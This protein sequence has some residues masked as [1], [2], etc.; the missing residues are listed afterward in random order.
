MRREKR[1]MSCRREVG[2]ES[3]KRTICNKDNESAEVRE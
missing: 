2:D 3:G 1:K